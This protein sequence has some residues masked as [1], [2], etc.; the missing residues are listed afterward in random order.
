MKLSVY[1]AMIKYNLKQNQNFHVTFT[2]KN[3][4]YIPEI[5]F[6]APR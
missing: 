1:V 2:P 4:I 3:I 6:I 5:I